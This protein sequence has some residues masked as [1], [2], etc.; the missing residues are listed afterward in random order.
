MKELAGIYPETQIQQGVAD[1]WHMPRLPKIRIPRFGLHTPGTEQRPAIERYI[2]DRFAAVHHA[3]VTHFLPNIISLR[4]SGEYSAAVGLAPAST[5]TLFAEQYLTAPVEKVISEKLEQPIERHQ[6]VEIGNLVSTWKGSSLLLFIVIGEVMERLGYHYVMFT[7]TR[8]VKAL[9]ARLHYSPIV[10]ADANPAVL[11]DG[12]ASW[13]SYYDNKPQVMFGD[14]RPAMAAARK[15]PMY[16]AT[17]LAINSAIEKICTEFRA[18]NNV[19][20]KDANDE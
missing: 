1:K 20:A 12:G 9:L 7:G 18:R 19:S 2:H 3:E 6:I 16:R 10:L 13:G 17:V 4:C 15:N 11:P 5:G 14:N 8:E